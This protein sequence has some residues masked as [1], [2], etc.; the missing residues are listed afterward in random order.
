MYTHTSTSPSHL[1]GTRARAAVSVR[2]IQLTHPTPGTKMQPWGSRKGHSCPTPT[3]LFCTITPLHVPSTRSDNHKTNHHAPHT[4][5]PMC[6]HASWTRHWAISSRPPAISDLQAS[7][8][9]SVASM[10]SAA[11]TMHIS[12]TACSHAQ[13]CFQHQA[14]CFCCVVLYI[15]MHDN[16]S[17]SAHTRMGAEAQRGPHALSVCRASAHRASETGYEGEQAQQLAVFLLTNG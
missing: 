10:H 9:P 15:M 6:F 8:M 2:T 4:L 1:P 11:S 16:G 12:N 17:Q 14:L 7:T 3:V 13:L 5:P